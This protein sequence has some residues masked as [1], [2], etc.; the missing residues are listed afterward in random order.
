MKECRRRKSLMA[1]TTNSHPGKNIWE[2]LLKPMPTFGRLRHVLTI[3][4]MQKSVDSNYTMNTSWNIWNGMLW[5]RWVTQQN[6]FDRKLLPL[7]AEST[8]Q[9]EETSHRHILKRAPKWNSWRCRAELNV[10]YC[11]STVENF[12]WVLWIRVQCP[13]IWRTRFHLSSSHHKLSRVETKTCIKMNAQVTYEL[14][15]KV[16]IKA[17]RFQS[18]SKP[19]DRWRN[20]SRPVFI[21]LQCGHEWTRL[22]PIFHHASLPGQHSALNRS[23]WAAS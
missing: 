1:L 10:I 9:R 7:S 13:M 18:T 20:A 15:N 4:Q 21:R 23:G 8:L 5:V 2:V 11:T 16:W 6:V 3:L 17:W 12:Q 19:T 22:L 14:K